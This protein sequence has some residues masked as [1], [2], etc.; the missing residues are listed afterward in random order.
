M[1]E[2]I[3]RADGKLI[4]IAALQSPLYASLLNEAIST[5]ASQRTR[6]FN[7]NAMQHA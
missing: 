1:E 2:F 5:V 7:L 3:R 6:V 4:C